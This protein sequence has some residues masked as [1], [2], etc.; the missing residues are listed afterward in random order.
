MKFRS[1]LLTTVAALGI[2][3]VGFGATSAQASTDLE[4]QPVEPYVTQ[5]STNSEQQSSIETYNIRDYTVTLPTFF[6]NY[7][8]T[9][10]Q[11]G[12]TYVTS[13][14]DIKVSSTGR[15]DTYFSTTAYVYVYRN[16]VLDHTITVIV[17]NG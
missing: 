17:G 5:I 12:M 9:F 11:P 1:A 13:N 10:H 3:G 2:S 16:G 14:N 15:L 7:Q 8:L 4:Q 6:K